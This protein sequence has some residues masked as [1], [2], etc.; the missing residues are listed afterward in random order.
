MIEISNRNKSLKDFK[1]QFPRLNN[2]KFI[3]GYATNSTKTIRKRFTALPGGG[4][5]R[6]IEYSLG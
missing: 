4:D 3:K 6:A 2:A 5:K 1:K